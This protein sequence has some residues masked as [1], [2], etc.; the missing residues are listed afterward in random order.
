VARVYEKKIFKKKNFSF[1][2][3][4]FAYGLVAKPQVLFA[5]QKS[6]KV[7]R[8]FI[9]KNKL[10]GCSLMVE[11]WSVDPKVAGSNLVIHHL[12][13]LFMNNSFFFL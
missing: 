12:L 2:I 13:C 11:R 8:P 10:G 1:I 7:L 5:T 6:Q 4:L 3:F 9:I